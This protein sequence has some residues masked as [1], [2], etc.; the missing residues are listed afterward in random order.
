MNLLG[1]TLEYT[2]RGYV[3]IKLDATEI[4]D[5]PTRENSETISRSMVVLTVTDTGNG[6]SSDFLRSKLFTPFAQENSLSLVGLVLAC[7]SCG[8]SLLS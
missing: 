6:I 3:Y 4:E 5:L 8:A 2:S 1:N 7:R